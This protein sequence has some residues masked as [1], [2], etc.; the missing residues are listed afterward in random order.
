MADG[1][2]HGLRYIEESSYGVTPTT[3]AFQTLRHTSC[4][5]ALS[6]NSSQSAEI[7][8]DRQISDLRHGAKQVGGDIGFELS[9]LTFDDLLEAVMGGTWATNVLKAGTTRRSFTF[10]RY[11]AD[12]AG[13]DKPFHRFTGCEINTM[14]L[15]VQPDARITGTFGLIGQGMNTDTA[16][17]A[18]ATYANPTTTA[19]LDSFTG[20]LSEGG[21]QIGVVTEITLDI[22][23]G[24]S[25]RFVIGSDVSARPSI[26]QSVI[27]GQIGVFFENSTLLDKFINETESSIEFT[28][29][30]AVGNS[31]TFELPRVKYNGGQP[32]VSGPGDIIL[33]MPFQALYDP[34]EQTNLKITRVNA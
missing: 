19:G 30:D 20:T 12:I 21:S 27:T 32:D 29:P 13:V 31:L 9:A 25:S 14:N 8:D 5:L 7:R 26:G 28:L 15:S 17:I 11:F 23:N 18:G 16:I 34:T 3:P 6:K 22:N 4:S 10:E 2:R 33:T 1:S 24:Q